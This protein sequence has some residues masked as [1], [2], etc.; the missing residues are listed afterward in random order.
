MD[1]FAARALIADHLAVP[2]ELVVGEASFRELGADSL[3]LITLTMR[4][5]EVF[6]VCIPDE[7]VDHCT[8]I[9]EALQLLR[10]VFA[11]RHKM[12]EPTG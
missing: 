2:V 5:E 11:S 1:E 12:L 8:T 6:D 7:Q 4:L 9:A 3:D 10:A